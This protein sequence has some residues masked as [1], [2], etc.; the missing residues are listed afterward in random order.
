MSTI[1]ESMRKPLA[2]KVAVVAGAARGAGRGIARMLGEA[3]ATVYCTG[4]SSRG[5]PNTT[6]HHYAGRPE[7]IEE[8][9]ELVTAAG[10]T[11]IPAR[12]DHSIDADVAELFTR[13]KR[14]QKRLDVL[15]NVLTGPPSTWKPSWQ[16]PLTEGRA[17][18]DG[19]VWPHVVTCWHATPL[20]LKRKAGLIVEIVEHDT[21]GFHGQLF[22]DLA[23]ISLKR[24]AY[25][26][27]EELAAH[28]VAALAVAPGFMRTE[29]IL[30]GFGTTEGRWRDVVDDPEPR[31]YGFVGSESPCFVGRAVAALAADPNVM[32]WSGGIYSSWGLSDEYGFTDADGA[33]PHWGRFSAEH[34]PQMANAA[35]AT[36]RLWHV[37]PPVV[38]SAVL[39]APA[40]AAR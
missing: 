31:R 20:M 16:I 24:L 12:V 23:I 22:Y 15:V 7:T 36:G 38:S 10:G 39:T 21:I 25:G 30:E 33:R 37:S 19:W 6:S 11:G 3:A 14:E 2:G 9:A 32:R 17:M 1:A 29:A 35:P 26:L 4:R 8:T 27:A 28:G 40:E 13:I 5:R 34:F 18:L